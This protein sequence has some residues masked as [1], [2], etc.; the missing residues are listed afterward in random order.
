MVMVSPSSALEGFVSDKLVDNNSTLILTDLVSLC[1]PF[2]KSE[3]DT[4][5]ETVY[6]PTLNELGAVTEKLKVVDAPDVR[7]P[8]FCVVGENARPLESE[9]DTVVP[10]IMS[11]PPLLKLTVNVEGIVRPFWTVRGC[12]CGD[13]LDTYSCTTSVVSGPT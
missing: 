10:Y 3:Y 13:Q 12:G 9:T 5:N 6:E 1:E 4:R 7:F 11:L 8:M 2:S